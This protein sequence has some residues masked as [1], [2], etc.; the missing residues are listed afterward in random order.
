MLP[1]AETFSFA[2][3]VSKLSNSPKGNQRHLAVEMAA[4]MLERLAWP[5]TA[6]QAESGDN[7]VVQAGDANQ[8]LWGEKCLLL[9]VSR[10]Y[11]K[12]MAT[13]AKA[14]TALSN[15]LEILGKSGFASP[16]ITNLLRRP[17]RETDRD[18][19][20]MAERQGE[21]DRDGEDEEKENVGTNQCANK[22]GNRVA[23]FGSKQAQDSGDSDIFS[24]L[25]RRCEDAK[26]NVRKAA[27][28]C[29]GACT[30][31]LCHVQ[32]DHVICFEKACHDP[33]VTVR[34][35]ARAF[36]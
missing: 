20:M 24:M 34:K 11:D 18:E 26:G 35:Q 25:K 30:R 36:P 2:G 33:L 29:W 19:E 12:G 23:T 4:A 28:Q 27:L 1:R 31:F 7:E 5:F 21:D 16:V 15:V 3:F 17:E 22:T 13:R 8:N 14:L 10:S 32:E 6:P 9:L